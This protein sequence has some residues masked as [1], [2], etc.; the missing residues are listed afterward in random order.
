MVVIEIKNNLIKIPQFTVKVQKSSLKQSIYIKLSVCVCVFHSIDLSKT[1]SYHKFF[2]FNKI[3][4]IQ[5]LKVSHFYRI[6]AIVKN[7][8]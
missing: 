3:E 7:L 5:N 8:I 1:V 4:I 6:L 2:W